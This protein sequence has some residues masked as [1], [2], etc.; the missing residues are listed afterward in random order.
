MGSPWLLSPAGRL[1][2][3][4]LVLAVAAL[5]A[6]GQAES[7]RLTGSVQDEAGQPVAGAEIVLAPASE[8]YGTEV[9]ARS[10]KK[11]QFA[12]PRV[13][14]GAYKPEVQGQGISLK[15]VA[16]AARSAEGVKVAEFQENDV[17]RN[18][19]P[20][21][22]ISP[23]MRGELT[24]VVSTGEQARERMALEVARDTSGELGKLNT[25]FEQGDWPKL[26]QESEKLL[27]DYPDL[28]GALYLR[29]AA[30]WRLGRVVEAIAGFRHAAEKDPQQ[31]GVHGALGTVLLEHGDQLAEQGRP[32]E[33]R[34]SHEEALHELERE[35]ELNP[36]AENFRANYVVVLQRLGRAEDEVNALREMLAQDPR[37]AM[38]RLRLGD[39]LT[40]LDR[41]EE[42]I[43][44][45]EASPQ[46]DGEIA[47]RIYNAAVVLWNAGKL[48]ET[49]AAMDKAIAIAPHLPYLYQLKGRALISKGELK[50]GIENL[51][52]FVERAPD[53][54]TAETDRQLI[55][56]LENQIAEPK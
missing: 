16:F 27:A 1:V 51:R 37:N 46:P 45:L 13:F 11:G 28:A 12:F 48:D 52:I 39:L 25:L 23:G 35:L 38:A 33:A 18:G 24:L 19:V 14:P 56:A 30:L 42:A 43:A 7:A 20:V 31:P 2:A 6:L 22:Q 44:A 15:S 55:E 32:Q 41:P 40:E 4:G 21:I 8:G 26:L 49:I 10:T 53:D 29:A 50:E 17:L 34:A 9:R 36:Q 47:I 3:L 5:P 54:P